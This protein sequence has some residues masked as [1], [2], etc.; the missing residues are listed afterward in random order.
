MLLAASSRDRMRIAVREPAGLDL[1]LAELL[2]IPGDAGSRCAGAAKDIEVVMSLGDIGHGNEP[3][4]RIRVGAMKP[5]HM[6]VPIIATC[7]PR[8]RDPGRIGRDGGID[9][10][11]R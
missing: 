9:P 7:C 5:Q 2:A 3:V 1:G 6:L 4:P 11:R 8:P 10:H